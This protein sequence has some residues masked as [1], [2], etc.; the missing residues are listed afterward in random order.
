MRRANCGC[1]S[2]IFSTT[3]K[4]SF[5]RALLASA[6][7]PSSVKYLRSIL[8]PLS[9]APSG[10]SGAPDT[11]TTACTGASPT[12][13][14]LSGCC[15]SPPQTA[16]E[17]ALRPLAVDVERDGLRVLGERTRRQHH[18]RVLLRRGVGREPA[19]DFYAL[20]RAGDGGARGATFRR[21]RHQR[22]R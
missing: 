7:L 16:I 21:E 6:G 15:S 2:V 13:V 10:T 1:G 17:R 8:K 19:R 14:T 18:P 20:D 11:V 22:G 12:L 4:R 5:C 3:A 9:A